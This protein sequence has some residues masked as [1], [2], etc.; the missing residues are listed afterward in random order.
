LHNVYC[1]SKN[2]DI[3]PKDILRSYPLEKVREV[4]ISGGSWSSSISGNRKAIRRDTHDDSV[5]AEVFELLSLVLCMCPELRFVILERIGGSMPDAIAQLEFSLDY[6]R[7]SKLVEATTD[8]NPIETRHSKKNILKHEG[9]ELIEFQD[10]LTALLHR[11]LKP[12]EMLKALRTDSHFK[13][14]Y[15]YVKQFDIDMISVASDLVK[16]WSKLK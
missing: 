12:A 7:L 1:Q 5:P 10:G 8:V 15:P 9:P 16:S 3:D 6:E 14:L 2:F 4:H 13:P 11:D